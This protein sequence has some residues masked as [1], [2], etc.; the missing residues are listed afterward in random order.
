MKEDISVRIVEELI[1]SKGD[2]NILRFIEHKLQ[3]GRID[4]ENGLIA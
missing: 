3:E 4:K 1:G 2:W